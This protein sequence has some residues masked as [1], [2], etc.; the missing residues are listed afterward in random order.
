MRMKEKAEVSEYLSN[1]KGDNMKNLIIGLVIGLILGGIIG[2]LIG[3][4][5]TRNSFSRRDNFQLD[6]KTKNEISSFFESTTDISIIESY[7]NQ[8]RFNC[9][10]YCRSVNPNHE[11]CSQMPMMRQGGD[12]NGSGN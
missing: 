1:Q 2:C 8:N 11:I 4:N 3:V 7:C 10:Y 5:L 12:I 9:M 6:E